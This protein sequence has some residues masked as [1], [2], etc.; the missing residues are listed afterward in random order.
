MAAQKGKDILIKIGDGASP[1]SFT[2]VAGV[3][4]RTL[5]LNAKTVDA[6]DSDS[7]GQWR[8]LLSG[9]GVRS[10]AVSGSGVFRDAGSDAMM[11]A[12]FFN[13]ATP[14]WQLVIPSFGV[15]QGPFQIAALEYA[16]QHEGEAT[17]S[18]SLASAGAL[19][20]T[21]AA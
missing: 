6:T 7:V 16:G 12:A 13:Q 2:T 8:E 1:E 9:G 5:S 17:F 14:N 3:R 18:I 4:T 15:I 20:F 11:Q 10:M 19:G 21:A